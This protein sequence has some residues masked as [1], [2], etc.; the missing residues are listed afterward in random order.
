MLRAPIRASELD[1]QSA[2]ERQ[3][4]LNIAGDFLIVVGQ[5]RIEVTHFDPEADGYF[6]DV[7]DRASVYAAPNTRVP[8]FVPGLN[9]GAVAGAFS[10]KRAYPPP[11]D[12]QGE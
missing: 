6:E 1:Q 7:D 3:I 5:P 8:V 10:R 9:D 11:N 4:I 12:N 2:R